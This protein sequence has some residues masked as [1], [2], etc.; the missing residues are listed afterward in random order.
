MGSGDMGGSK[1]KWK[2]DTQKLGAPTE[3]YEGFT[4]L[5]VG[6]MM[7]VS[8]QVQ[9]NLDSFHFVSGSIWFW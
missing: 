6:I 7:Y 4:E 2:I 1:D 9:I 3:L 8:I 5:P